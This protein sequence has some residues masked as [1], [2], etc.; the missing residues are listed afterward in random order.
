MRAEKDSLWIRPRIEA[1]FEVKCPGEDDRPEKSLMH[2]GFLARHV[3]DGQTREWPFWCSDY[4][5]STALTFE[6]AGPD[7]ETRWSI[8]AAF[9]ELL[10]EAHTPLADYEDSMFHSGCGLTIRFGKRGGVWFY[11]DADTG[12]SCLD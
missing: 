12:K 1:E 8:A 2:F 11:E 4:H 9:W 3:G 7:V 6:P 10:L 5:G